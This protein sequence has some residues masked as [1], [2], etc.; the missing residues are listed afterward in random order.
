V[1]LV[2]GTVDR[3]QYL[4]SIGALDG[5]CQGNFRLVSLSIRGIFTLI[6]ESDGIQIKQQV[7]WKRNFLMVISAKPPRPCWLT[8]KLWKITRSLTV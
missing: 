7:S 2:A 1:P 5:S 4:A 8:I 3:A 6:R